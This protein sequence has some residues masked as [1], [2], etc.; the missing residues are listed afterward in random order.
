MVNETRRAWASI[1]KKFYGIL[2]SEKGS[3]IFKRSIYTSKE[4]KKGELFTKNNIK[5]IR[6][7]KGVQPK[8]Y[9]KILG[10]RSLKN[11]KAASPLSFKHFK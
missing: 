10:K 9:E 6:P 3:L 4:I 5:V 1:G 8:F 2:K 7:N 11:I